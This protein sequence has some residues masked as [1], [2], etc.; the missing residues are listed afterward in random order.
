MQGIFNRKKLITF[1][2]H[3]KILHTKN[4]TCLSESPTCNTITHNI[5]KGKEEKVT[6]AS[7]YFLASILASESAS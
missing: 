2:V 5:K 3:T 7:T 4:I 1:S 6:I